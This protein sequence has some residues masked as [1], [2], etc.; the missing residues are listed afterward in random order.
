M[1]IQLPKEYLSY[2][3]LGMWLSNKEGYRARYYRNEDGIRS[4]E[5]DFGKE[6]A[7]KLENNDPSVSYVPR[8]TVCEQKIVTEIDGIKTLSFLDAFD[9]ITGEFREYKT[10]KKPWDQKR[11]MNHLQL[12]FYSAVVEQEHKL[13][14]ELCHLDW[15]QTRNGIV[16][17]DVMGYT[18]ECEG[19]P[20]EVTGK[21]ESFE[22]IITKN[23]RNFIRSLIVKVA[24]EISEDYKAY[25]SLSA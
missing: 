18:V 14:H 19:G 11:V 21:M 23:D 2:S 12:D 16:L 13:I 9:P 1:S 7:K 4:P 17:K 25:L 3:Q 20:I 8:L 6:F 24:N 15:I 22:R 10:G 5:M